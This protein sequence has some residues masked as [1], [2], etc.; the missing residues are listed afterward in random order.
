MS[1][2]RNSRRLHD[3]RETPLLPHEELAPPTD[4]VADVAAREGREEALPELFPAMMAPPPQPV[5]RS[6]RRAF[7]TR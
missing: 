3:W 2:R 4:D 1:P 7:R 6:A 5:R